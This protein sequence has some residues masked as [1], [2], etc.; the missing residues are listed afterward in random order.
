MTIMIRTYS[1]LIKFP[2][3]EERFEYLKLSGS[4]GDSTFGFERCLNQILYRSKEWKHIRDCVIFRDNGCDLGIED[5]LIGG[6]IIV[7]HMNPISIKDVENRDKKI[8]DPEY[9]IC[10]S[11]ITHN[12]LHYGDENLLIKDYVERSPN[13]T[14]PWK[15]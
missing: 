5:R 13:D 4:I 9:L 8:F 2:T 3:F 14:S 6:R 15:H 11:H 7:H 1:D 12:A 10:V